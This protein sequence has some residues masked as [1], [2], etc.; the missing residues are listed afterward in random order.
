MYINYIE[1]KNIDIRAITKKSNDININDLTITEYGDIEIEASVELMGYD[2][3]EEWNITSTIILL[4][5]S[6]WAQVGI[7]NE[8]NQGEDDYIANNT[9]GEIELDTIKVKEIDEDIISD[10]YNDLESTARADMMDAQEEYY[11][12]EILYFKE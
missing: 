2:G 1:L 6:Y 10:Y 8:N 5:C 11:R 12:H 3:E 7:I 4:K 9:I